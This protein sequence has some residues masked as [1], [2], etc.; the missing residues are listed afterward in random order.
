MNE[1][2][3]KLK[4]L[5][6][7]KDWSLYRLA[8]ES[9]LPY[10]SISNLFR[11]NTEPTIPTLRL[12]CKGFGISLSDFFADEPAPQNLDY[13]L[14]EQNLIIS[15]R[16]LRKKDRQLLSVYMS[17]LCKKLPDPAE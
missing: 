13:S 10:S 6:L 5:L 7:Q 2:C 3:T 16:S 4:K 12:I 1:T 8:A 11:R 17:G 15:Y 9:G 14:E